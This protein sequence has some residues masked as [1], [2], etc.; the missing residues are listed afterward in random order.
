MQAVRKKKALL[1]TRAWNISDW[2][3]QFNVITRGISGSATGSCGRDQPRTWPGDEKLNATERQ[4]GPESLMSAP[5]PLESSPPHTF[6]PRWSVS[7]LLTLPAP[8]IHTQLEYKRGPGPQFSCCSRERRDILGNRIKVWWGFGGG[9]Q[10]CM[11]EKKE[12]SES[13]WRRE[14]EGLGR[15]RWGMCGKESHVVSCSS[16]EGEKCCTKDG[17]ILTRR[18]LFFFLRAPSPCAAWAVK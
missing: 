6:Q 2:T 1:R 16:A 13:W 9:V 10:K 15:R 11:G 12:D 3:N 4:S 7:P 8:V 18:F 5:Q 17:R 14:G